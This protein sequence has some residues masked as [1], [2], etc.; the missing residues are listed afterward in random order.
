MYQEEVQWWQ[1]PGTKILSNITICSSKKYNY[2][3]VLLQWQRIKLL[4]FKLNLICINKPSSAFLIFLRIAT[5][6][7]TSQDEHPQ[8][9]CKNF[10]HYP[11]TPIVLNYYATN[12]MYNKTDTIVSYYLTQSHSY[13]H[14]VTMGT[15]LLGHMKLPRGLVSLRHSWSYH[16]D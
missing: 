10:F 11:V 1:F 7:K 6:Y 9:Q 15:S 13:S 5:L 8:Y 12:F 3:S 14:E 4:F 2:L 16:G